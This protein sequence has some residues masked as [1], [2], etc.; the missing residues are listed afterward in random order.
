MLTVKAL[1]V[2]LVEENAHRLQAHHIV[3]G[4]ELSYGSEGGTRRPTGRRRR[5]TGVP[6]QAL[7]AV[8]QQQEGTRHRL[9]AAFQKTTFL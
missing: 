3:P 4:N 5:G 9:P 6:G 1:V 8:P 2:R 7:G